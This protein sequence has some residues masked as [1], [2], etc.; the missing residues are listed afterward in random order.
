MTA[1][2]LF[3][4]GMDSSGGAGLLR[5]TATAQALGAAFRVAVTAVTAQSDREVAAT[6][7]VPPDMVT[8]QIALATAG[9]IA[10]AK[11]GMLANRPVVEAVATA[12]P[13]V[14]LVV[15]PVLCASSGAA[16]LDDEG[17]EALIT[18]LLPKAA[19]I[20]PN[21]PELDAISAHIGRPG[22]PEAAVA[23]AL[24]ARGA[25]AVLVKGGHGGG[26]DMCEDRLYRPGRERLI[27]SSPRFPGSLRGT[28]C[29]LASAIAIGL[30][31]GLD[32][33]DAVMLAR[34]Q[35]RARFVETARSDSQLHPGRV[36]LR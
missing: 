25:A 6:L 5:D 2:V 27:F 30:G 33:P 20:T 36:A 4:G 8:T 31:R 34:A 3:I 7:S 29:Q 24:M 26:K 14:P 10:V 32:L 19:L 15:D 18:H 35:V 1:P 28:G 16:L 11:T 23:E 13:A 17:L 9:G 21:L 12:L 22:A